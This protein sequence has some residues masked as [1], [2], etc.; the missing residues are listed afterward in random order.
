MICPTL[1]DTIIF[2]FQQLY[3]H[4]ILGCCF[5]SCVAVR[6]I[7]LPMCLKTLLLLSSLPSTDSQEGHFLNEKGQKMSNSEESSLLLSP[8]SSA[9]SGTRQIIDLRNQQEIIIFNL[10]FLNKELNFN[11]LNF[12]KSNLC[13][14]G[15][16]HT[17]LK[18]SFGLPVVKM[19]PSDGFVQVS[20]LRTIPSFP[21][22]VRWVSSSFS[23]GSNRSRWWAVT[24]E[25]KYK[26]TSLHLSAPP[27]SL[28][29][30]AILG[31]ASWHLVSQTCIQKGPRD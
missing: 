11:Q 5:H 29:D 17:W 21:L 12:T 1:G 14:S 30:G 15:E 6:L 27:L 13:F 19:V 10:F 4:G 18:R 26:E 16:P 23:K 2:E 31:K 20:R 7:P 9:E 3:F 22:N 25:T 24:S 8:I 28:L